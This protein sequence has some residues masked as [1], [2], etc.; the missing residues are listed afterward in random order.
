MSILALDSSGAPREWISYEQAIAYH[1]TDSVIWSLGN[2]VAKF[3]GGTRKDG[4]LSYI[5][6]SSI[7]A[8]RGI[9][10]VSRKQKLVSLSNRT[11]FGRDRHLCAYCGEHFAN[12]YQLSRD[13]IVPRSRGGLDSWMNVVTACRSCNSR[14]SN[15]T[16][17]EAG[18]ELLYVP[19][20]P[21]HYENMI[22]QNRTILGCQMEY[23]LGGVP[24]HSRI[25]PQ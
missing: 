13:H 25:R 15:K 22:L 6:S 18:L 16:L 24:K 21:N 17:S 14:K 10:H 1:A 9:S 7:I 4:T 23:L 5:E 20:V 12:F 11:L 8:I 19:Y 2:V 3:R